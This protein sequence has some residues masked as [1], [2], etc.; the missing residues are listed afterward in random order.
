MTEKLTTC[1]ACKSQ[2]LEYSVYCCQCG[3]PMR[4]GIPVRY[5]RSQWG[6]ILLISLILSLLMTSGLQLLKSCGQDQSQVSQ[7]VETVPSSPVEK[8]VEAPLDAGLSQNLKPSGGES[9]SGGT[10]LPAAEDLVRGKVE[11]LSRTG[12]LLNDIPATVVGGS[13]IALP[14]QVCIG[15]TTWIFKSGNVEI[16]IVAG[17]W[18]RGNAVG[19][20]HLAG[21]EIFSGPGVAAWRPAEPVSF[22]SYT[23]GESRDGLILN[24]AGN[25]GVFAYCPLSENTGPG[26]LLQD[27][28][29]VGWVF[30]DVLPGA[31]MWT[32]AAQ[33]YYEKTVTVEDFYNETFAGGREDFFSRALASRNNEPPLAQL[34]MFVEAFWYPPKLTPAQTPA[35]LQPEAVYPYIEELIDFLVTREQ[36]NEIALLAD[37]PLVTEIGS[38]DI[39][40]SVARAVQKVYGTATAI[41]FIEG[42]ESNTRRKN[43]GG[44][45]QLDRLH[46]E[47]YADWIGSLIENR[48]FARGWQVF[49]RAENRF[50][51]SPEIHLEG[52][53]L[54]LAEGDWARAETLLYQKK[55]P[56]ALRDRMME[57]ANRISA[58]KGR[59]NQI[60]INFEPGAKEIP[61]SATINEALEQDFL[62]DTGATFVTIPYATVDSLGLQNQ[63]TGQ[64]EEVKTAGGSVYANVVI[65]PS[66]ELQGWVV[67]D[68]RALVL[69][70]PDRPGLGLL[71]LNYLHRFRMDLQ[72][73]DGVLILEPQ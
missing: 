52:V 58:L 38:A 19:F 40:K 39:V 18:E 69:D 23:S 32:L 41:N 47:L 60:I 9:N 10:I 22:F 61:V 6:S 51:D 35:Y 3:Q 42:K 49:D 2:N 45:P 46:M 5:R 65:L 68:V 70:L 33:N 66:I 71:G 7:Q 12:D 16:P 1:P 11:I 50:V 29:A 14:V 54:A 24:A 25:D 44:T 31:F 8:S 73:E 30:G 13:W 21:N 48:D 62:I 64:T 63:L 43:E 26:I 27:G 59:E 20:W 36:Y 34:Q 17:V 57:L 37:E 15:G 72:S 67:N 55:Y 4:E 28:N 56:L 53:Q